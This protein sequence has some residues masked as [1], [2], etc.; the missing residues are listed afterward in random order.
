MNRTLKIISAKLDVPFGL[1][2]H[3]ARHTYRMLLDEA[4]IVDPSVICK[5]MGWSNKDRMDSIYRKVTDSRLL[6]TKQKLD[7]LIQKL[8]D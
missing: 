5:L 6:K 2:S 7:L 3:D 4:D 1:S 8:I